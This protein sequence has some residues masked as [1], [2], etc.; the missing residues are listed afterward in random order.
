M[1]FKSNKF[2]THMK[3]IDCMIL[4]KKVLPTG[5]IIVE[6]WVKRGF[7]LG[8]VEVIVIDPK[9]YKNWRMV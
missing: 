4:V 1:L 9:E 8:Q 7:S 5:S 3:M 2:Y 6:W